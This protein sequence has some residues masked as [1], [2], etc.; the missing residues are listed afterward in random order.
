[1]DSS[2]FDNIIKN[3]LEDHVD[4]SG[5]SAAEMSRMLDSMPQTPGGLSGIST[6]TKISTAAS[7]IFMITTIFLI[8]RTYLL[9]DTLT[10]VQH[11][12]I[13]LGKQ[14]QEILYKY[15]TLYWNSLQHYTRQAIREQYTQQPVPVT[16]QQQAGF[17]FNAADSER[18]VGQLLKDLQ[19]AIE[20]DPEFRATILQ[21]L[22]LPEQELPAFEPFV[23]NAEED[24]NPIKEEEGLIKAA[25]TQPT[26]T[27]LTAVLLDLASNEEHAKKLTNI[28][29][30]M[31]PDTPEEDQLT[32]PASDVLKAEL[33]AMSEEEQADMITD[34]SRS[35]PQVTNASIR[36]LGLDSVF[37][38]TL[39]RNEFLL[40]TLTVEE[41][42]LQLSNT[43]EDEMPPVI[44][45]EK[46]PVA[47]WLNV[48][49]GA[50]LVSINSAGNPSTTIFH[51]GVER[52]IGDRIGILAGA[53]FQSTEGESYDVENFDFSVFDAFESED[54]KEIKTYLTWMD[55]PI[56]ARFYVLPGRKVNP[57]L[58][59]SLKV[60]SLLRERYVVETNSGGELTPAFTNNNS[61]ISFPAFGAGAGA[62]FYLN[63]RLFGEVKVSQSFGG[64]ELDLLGDRLNSL[65]AQGSLFI[66]LSK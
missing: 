28:L 39:D 64:S 9:N 55:I 59:V 16:S 12:L 1:M 8:Y 52:R 61:A 15:D 14:N 44:R 25:V 2:R 66:R 29:M 24:E 7:V 31:D 19:K 48:G 45:K 4:P 43:T 58:G 26:K 49:G 17:Q 23:T 6:A 37:E 51:A 21:Q 36:S 62:Q 10:S 41:D 5:P 46:R 22:D 42:S 60:R 11:E 53:E 65:Q 40:S 57:F 3:K 35:E 13:N 38:K 34:F 47:W 33:M 20:E 56:E 32:M 18:L 27:D 54:I 63:P 30:G 50:G